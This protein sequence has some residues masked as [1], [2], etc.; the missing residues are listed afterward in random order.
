MTNKKAI[1]LLTS[2]LAV[3]LFSLGIAHADEPEIQRQATFVLPPALQEIEEEA[4]SGTAVES[5][6][7]PEG[8]LR[9]GERAFD[10]AWRLTDVYIPE[11]TE[12]IAE[13]AFSITPDLTIHGIE[14]SYAHDWAEA[15]EIPFVAD[16]VWSMIPLR[17]GSHGPRTNP[18]YRYIATLVLLLNLTLF[19]NGY[20]E[21]RS[22]R[23]QDRPELN[24]IDYRFP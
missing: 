22:R 8:F 17:R 10:Q 20:Y 18:I 6:V 16:D 11:T 21:Y 3:L 4:F 15:H 9:I 19:R 7:L 12:Y 23:P 2:L 5:V 14:G 1:I 24:P 13:T